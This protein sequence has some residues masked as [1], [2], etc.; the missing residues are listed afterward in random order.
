MPAY[1]I[2][3]SIWLQPSSR[4]RFELSVTSVVLELPCRQAVGVHTGTLW[5]CTH[6]PCA[7][8]CDQTDFRQMDLQLMGPGRH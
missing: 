5:G 1:R 2:R 3:S 6:T 7:G 8:L 4:A